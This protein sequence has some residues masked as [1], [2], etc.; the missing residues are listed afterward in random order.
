[1]ALGRTEGADILLE[2]GGDGLA[3]TAPDCVEVDEHGLALGEESVPI[4]L[5]VVIVSMEEAK[6][7]TRAWAWA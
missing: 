1:M 2:D 4:G 5:A 7:R 6:P 3:G